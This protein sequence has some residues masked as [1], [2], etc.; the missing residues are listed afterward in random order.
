MRA[1]A[2]KKE[3]S[4]VPPRQGRPVR[5]AGLSVELLLLMMLLLHSDAMML[6]GCKSFAEPRSPPALA[7]LPLGGVI[8]PSA[9]IDAR[10]SSFQARLRRRRVGLGRMDDGSR[11]LQVEE[12]S[13]EG[14]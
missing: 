7:L 10:V 4:H 3:K 9:I 2:G 8:G 12:V 1:R 14:F 5:R 13:G 11:R 6:L